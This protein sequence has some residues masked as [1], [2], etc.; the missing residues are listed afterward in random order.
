MNCK[1][2]NEKLHKVKVETGDL[3]EY[4][5]VYSKGLLCRNSFEVFTIS[6]KV[7]HMSVDKNWHLAIED[8]NNDCLYYIEKL[9]NKDTMEIYLFSELQ[10]K[11]NDKIFSGYGL[12]KD[13]TA[14]QFLEK[15]HKI[16]LF[17]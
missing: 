15:I 9:D 8:P 6:E 11:I 5:N 4:A 3:T 14:E 10:N 2:C 1:V 17:Q 12:S 16:L 13:F 7:P